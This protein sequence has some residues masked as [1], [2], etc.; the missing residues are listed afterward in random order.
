M[1]KGT[2]FVLAASLYQVPVIQTARQLGYRVITTDNIASNPGHRLADRSYAIDTTDL[3]AVSDIARCE[4]INGIIAACTDVAVPTMAYVAK[5]LNLPGIS[6]TCAQIA[7]NK[8]AFR[9]FLQHHGFPCPD[10]YIITSS[11][12]PDPGL[13]QHTKWVLKP[14]QSSGSKGVFIVNSIAD[15]YKYLPD[16]L[17]FSPHQRG[18]LEIFIDGVQGTCE[19]VIQNRRLAATFLLDRQTLSQP[20]STTC[21]HRLPSNLT[22]DLQ[23]RLLAD[24]QKIWHLLGV[25]DSPFDCDFVAT[26]TDIYILELSPRIGGNSITNLL[27]QAAGFDLIE[28]SIKLACR[29]SARLPQATS[30]RPAAIIL[31]GVSSEGYLDYDAIEFEAL[32]KEAWVNSISLDLKRGDP[33]YPFRNSRYR[34]G[35]ALIFG[36]DRADLDRKAEELQKRLQLR[37]T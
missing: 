3:Q 32:R 15:F 5:Q 34:V 23:E 10:F 1:S 26:K 11:S 37:A 7:C 17:S 6:P 28:Y 27:Q 21:G 22:S 35:E 9:Q 18:I 30:I 8:V 33:V 36:E 29:E 16:T 31:F 19:G 4:K 14:D 24:L 2:I 20:Y 13:F 25:V 12:K